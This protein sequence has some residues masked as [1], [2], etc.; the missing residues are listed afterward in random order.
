[1]NDATQ[2]NTPAGWYPVDGNNERYWNGS[3][4]SDQVRPAPA[5]T[6]AGQTQPAGPPA[7]PAL[8]LG[9]RSV[10]W[11][12]R[13]WVIAIA[14][15]LVG[16]G[17]GSASG[18][19]DP[20]KTSEYKSV[21]KDL[22]DAQSD[23][24]TAQSELDTA[25]SDLKTIAGELPE[26]EAQLKADQAA[27]AKAQET[28][29]TDQASLAKAQAAVAKREKKVG[30]VETEIAANTIPGDGIYE[31]GRDMKAGTYRSGAPDS[32]NCYHSVNADANG[33]DIKSNNNTAGPSLVNV[34]NGEF[35]ETSGCNEWV[36]SR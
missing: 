34:S 1:M 25:T 27:L 13:G 8:G 3:D 24:A 23:L 22:K 19:T 12:R 5:P 31:V 2:S 18:G 14:A 35:F 15:L 7:V 6:A 21:A 9:A 10:P 33:D 28:L 16:V 4:W 29:S 26:R 17:I 30:I 36:L 11:Y 20:T 32:G